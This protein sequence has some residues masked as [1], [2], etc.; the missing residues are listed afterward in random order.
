MKTYFHVTKKSKL[1]EILASGLKP[2]SGI[3]A[4]GMS[5]DSG[6]A[7]KY[8]EQDRGL[9]YM[10]TKVGYTERFKKE[11][12]TYALV[13][14]RLDDMFDGAH[15]GVTKFAAEEG[16][17]KDTVG[18]TTVVCNATIPVT[19]LFYWREKAHRKNWDELLPLTKWGSFSMAMGKRDTEIWGGDE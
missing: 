19:S 1:P 12:E 3:A 9:I 15:V 16:K 10:W 7:S 8:A 17:T 4:G 6:E 2:S 5:A 14:V 13:V 11:H 18:L